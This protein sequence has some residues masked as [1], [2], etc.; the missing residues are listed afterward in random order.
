M[1]E[2][3]SYN[4]SS[5]KPPA[6]ANDGGIVLVTATTYTPQFTQLIGKGKVGPVTRRLQ[7]T[8]KKLTDDSG[9]PIYTY[10]P[11]TL[12]PVFD[13]IEYTR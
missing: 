11:R 9:I 1:P 10:L 6:Y 7:S 3:D 13:Q 4:N 5:W 12:N 2:K 8:Y